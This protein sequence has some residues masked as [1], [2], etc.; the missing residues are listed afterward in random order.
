M[1]IAVF[2]TEITSFFAKF[3]QLFYSNFYMTPISDVTKKSVPYNI[4][5]GNS[6]WISSDIGFAK[7]VGVQVNGV[8]V[9]AADT[10]VKIQDSIDGI[11]FTDITGASITLASGSSSNMY[12]ISNFSGRFVKAVLVVGSSVVGT[13]E[14]LCIAKK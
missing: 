12:R 13:I 11:N 5:G 7:F 3:G 9:S 4:S 1:D 10:I 2:R 6:S 8:N 14:V